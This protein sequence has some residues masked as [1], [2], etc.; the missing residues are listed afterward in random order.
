MIRTPPKLTD[1]NEVAKKSPPKTVTLTS[2]VRK[3]IDEWE[4]A[5]SD[6]SIETPVT[7]KRP[8]AGPATQKKRL[9]LSQ[10]SEMAKS[11]LSLSDT[12]SPKTAHQNRLT[13]AKTCITRVKQYLALSRNLKSNLKTGISNA[14]D[15]LYQL[16][17]ELDAELKR[18]SEGSVE[19]G[20]KAS[21]TPGGNDK[22]G[23][24]RK[25]EDAP[26]KDSLAKQIEEHGR[27][28]QEHRGEM[29]SLQKQLSEQREMFEGNR[30]YANV[31]AGPQR[32]PSQEQPSMHSVVITSQ[33]EL[34]TGDQVLEKVRK[35]V[36]ARQ[37]GVRIDKV[38]Q[39][40]DRKVIIGCRNK[41]ELKK[42]RDKIRENGE[43]L[44][45]EEVKNKD[46]LV[47][48]YGVLKSNTNN[49]IVDALRNQN[50]HLLG[51]KSGT[52]EGIEIVY[53]RRARNPHTEHVV[54]RVSPQVWKR[55]TEAGAVHIDLQR[56]RVADQSPLV[57]CSRCLGYGHGKRFCREEVDVCSHCGGPHMRTQCKGWTEA[58]VPDCINCNKAKI[59]FRD[60][61]AFSRECPANLQ[62]S[63]LATAEL[64]VECV[65]RKISVALIQEP[66][67]GCTGRVKSYPGVKV[68]QCSGNP[69]N[70]NKTAIALFDDSID[71][72]QYPTLT[73]HN[74]T[75]VK[76]RTGAWEVG[77][78][79]VY[80]DKDKP[81]DPD[82]QWMTKVKNELGTANIVIGGDVNAWNP[83]WGS[84][85]MNPRGEAL[86]YALDELGLQILNEGTKPTFDVIRGGKRFTSCVDLTA[87]STEILGSVSNWRLDTEMTS[88]DHNAILFEFNLEKSI[89][90]D[91]KRT[92]RIYNTKKANWR[93]FHEKLTQ[94]WKDENINKEEID[95]INKKPTGLPWWNDELARLKQDVATKKRR[96]KCAAQIR[97]KVVTDSYLQAKENYQCEAKKAQTSSWKSFCGRQDRESMWEGIYRV[98]ARTTQRGEDIPLVKD[99]TVLGGEESAKLL[100]ETFFPQDSENEDSAAHRYIRKSAE[101][102]NKWTHGEPCDPEFTIEELNTAAL[103]FNVKKAPGKEG[104]TADICRAA[105]GTNPE[106]FLA[107]YNR[108]IALAQFPTIWKEAT[109]V[110]LPKHG[111]EDY[112]L[113]KSYRPI[114]L[115][116]VLGKILE[117]MLIKRIRWH[118]MPKMSRRQYGFT[119]QRSTEDSL[120]VMMKHIRDKLEER[121]LISLISLD[122]E[123]AFDSAW[124]P[125]IRCRLAE[126]ECPA[127]LRRLVDSYLSGRKV[128][129]RYA[130]AESV[131][132]TTKG[133]VQGSIGGPTF[134]NLLLDPLL[135][136]LE[137]KGVHCQAFADDVVLIFSGDNAEQI[138]R[139]ADAALEHVQRWGVE[140]K[141]KFAPHK[142]QAMVITNKIKYD[143]PRLTMGGERIGLS[144]EIKILGLTVDDKL[145]FNSHVRNVCRKAIAL[146]KQLARTAKIS[147]GLHPEVI[148]TIY[149]AVIEPT[150]MYAASA[151]S[152]AT[153]K[154]GVKKQLDMVQRGFAQ[155]ITKAYRTVSLHSAL[156]LSGLLP[157]DIR[158]REAASLYEVK[159]G[160][161]RRAIAD[162]ELETPT[163]FVN[164][165][166]PSEQIGT[167]FICLADGAALEQHDNHGRKIF[168]DGSKIEGKV[169]AALSIWDGET[170]TST[171]KLKLDQSCTVY[172]A[173]LLA[174]MEAT[175][176]AVK[177]EASHCNVYSDSRSALETIADGTS[178][179][180]LAVKTRA[181]INTIQ[182]RNNIINLFWIKAHEGMEGNERADELAKDAALNKKSKADYDKCPVSFVK[183]QIRK[184]SLD[185]WNRRYV[186]GETAST[187]KV[188]FP[189]AIAANRVIR[190]MDLDPLT[191]QLMTGH[192][193]FSSYLYRFKC[194]ESPSCQC[195]D[196]TEENVL[197]LVVECPIYARNRFDAE[198]EIGREINEILMDTLRPGETKGYVGLLPT[199]T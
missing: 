180:P 154:L 184:D 79:S 109:I 32:G 33:D 37:E 143:S 55:L 4:A 1:A 61:S 65:K 102:G 171:R 54:A 113:P 69:D 64:V 178:L 25:G 192:G 39:A 27:L 42:V 191:V 183:R 161:S 158:I 34:E 124:W 106:A 186:G 177:H 3:S 144:R 57:Q 117:K 126:S 48:F 56:I 67:T 181:N 197:H 103:S 63:E 14:A 84:R 129:V 52:E 132:D 108:C 70:V 137:E 22:I 49:E 95:K 168:T 15:R 80:L 96:I 87:C 77:I 9:P 193:G 131:R 71:I 6:P 89:G 112:T 198:A 116:P 24:E 5:G 125:A 122:I 119:P 146:Y 99:G 20:K 174:L 86:A 7:S 194:R 123:G 133:C 66:Y 82:I 140:N 172:Q 73:T 72:V 163:P 166:H 148:R 50:G 160:F 88:S 44:H 147:W 138:E 189:D 142:T 46:P 16:V 68:V 92:T 175:S 156:L 38:R 31:A 135:K 152:M 199:K 12:R 190:K 11:P 41:D 173:E 188:F 21:E 23:K 111:K 98:I 150:I 18:K 8:Q 118:T 43:R 157:L 26:E 36:N 187:T 130:G 76:L 151:W 139:Q 136:G 2:N 97:R 81:I 182:K 78:V 13:E 17:K 45:V 53:R 128:R 59:E 75:V 155:K 165:P 83:W 164:L 62:R 58:T 120:Y 167:K 107:L 60:H 153:N 159:K 93:E 74:F 29:V 100:A 104:F 149:T 195:S 185:E 85:K 114:G 141:L 30:T 19:K 127:N 94:V 91:I 101:D 28:L 162:R 179:H 105:I 47:I 196:E 115:L 169:G 176:H 90:I 35:V 145:T 40:R 121:K 170:E 110:V 134:W 10:D 51:G